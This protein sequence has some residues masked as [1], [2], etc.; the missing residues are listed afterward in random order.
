MAN[1][2]LI[3]DGH[4]EEVCS[5]AA[6]D[7]ALLAP[8]QQIADVAAIEPKRHGRGIWLAGLLS[9]ARVKPTATH[10]TLHSS[11]DDFHAS[12]PLAAVADR[13]FLIYA[14]GDGQLPTSAGGPFRFFI[15]DHAACKTAEVDECA[16]VKFVDRIE[17]TAGPGFDNR[18]RDEGEHAKLHEK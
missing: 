15:R 1:S 17:L 9:A 7:L 2:Q 11:A 13:A 5:F 6:A 16:N 3:I 4:V 18:P 10:V 14:V 12:V 8:E